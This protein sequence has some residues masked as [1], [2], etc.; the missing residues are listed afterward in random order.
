MP[1]CLQWPATI[2]GKPFIATN[3]LLQAG[4]RSPSVRT[5]FCG[6]VTIV[7]IITHPIN[8]AVSKT[9]R[10]HPKDSQPS[11]IQTDIT[12]AAPNART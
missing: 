10:T 5:R 11:R 1:Q 6:P 7:Y 9:P 2:V 12:M 3:G 8:V 4:H